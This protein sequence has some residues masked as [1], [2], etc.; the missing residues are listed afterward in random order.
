MTMRTWWG[1]STTNKWN[2]LSDRRRVGG[3]ASIP[4]RKIYFCCTVITV[5]AL[6]QLTD[7]AYCCVV[8]REWFA[9]NEKS[10]IPL[11]QS[12]RGGERERERFSIVCSC[13]KEKR[14]APIAHIYIMY[15]TQCTSRY[16]WAATNNC[17]VPAM[18][19]LRVSLA[20]MLI[21]RCAALFCVSYAERPN[22]NFISLC[23]CD[24]DRIYVTHALL[25]LLISMVRCLHIWDVRTVT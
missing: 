22:L 6:L 3:M 25:L 23:R 9:S 15:S 20:H 11:W 16:K 8:R 21:E 14:T 12:Q 2:N 4:K 24:V 1:C 10:A 5:C 7:I 13:I 17:I 19:T 18:D